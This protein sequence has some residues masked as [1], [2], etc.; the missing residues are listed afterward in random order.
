MPLRP[1][2]LPPPEPP[3]VVQPS[4]TPAPPPPA[5]EYIEWTPAG[6]PALP[7]SQEAYHGIHLGAIDEAYPSIIGLDMPPQEEFDT[8]LP[9]GGELFNGRRWAARNIA[10]PIVIH[11]DSPDE[12]RDYR[13]QLMASFNPARGDG[14]LTIA[15][16]DGTRRHI[17]CRYSNGLDVAEYGR[18]G[19]PYIDSFMVTMKARDPFP[20]GDLRTVSFDPPQSYQFFAPPGDPNVFYISS[21]TTTGDAD[22]VIDGE[23]EVF[24]EWGLDGPMTT[25]TLRNRDTNKTLSLTPNL[26][27]NQ[28]LTVRMDPRTAPTRKFTRENGSN[29]WS[30]VAGQF[31]VMWSL[32]PGLNRVTVNLAGT[33]PDQSGGELRY[34]PRYLSA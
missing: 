16:P 31:P 2:L 10:L 17:D 33:V 26:S 7:L 8:V 15:Y 25:A 13:R 14:V 3:V 24:G 5:R 34:R 1:L 12:L 11:A 32:Q 23:V 30:T 27:V 18:T 4:P 20:Y 6:G 21:A 19:Y 28:T 9:G 29:V 22:V